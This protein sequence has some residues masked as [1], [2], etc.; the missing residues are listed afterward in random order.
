LVDR[1]L[2]DGAAD[3]LA[4]DNL[5]TGDWGH[6][7]R[8]ANDSRLVRWEADFAAATPDVL[9]A[10]LQ[11]CDVLFHLAAEKHNQ[12]RDRPTRVFDVNVQGTWRLLEAAAAAG[13]RKVV[14]T[15]SLYA[16]GGMVGPALDEADRPNPWTAYGISKLAGEQMLTHFRRVH[17]LQSAC[18]R[19]FFTYG[20]RQ[21]AGMGYKSVI[22][23]S[24]E[25]L[26]AGEP[27]AICGSGQQ[28]LDYVYIDDVVDALVRAAIR[29]IGEE[30]VNIASGI[31]RSVAEL[32]AAIAA[33][34][35]SDLSPRHVAADW[36]EGTCR[37]GT[38]ER[39]ARLL[40]WR[41]VTPLEAGLEATYAWMRQA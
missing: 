25:H 14:F 23:R 8:W 34:A 41:A 2:V 5:H 40:D 26:M 21:F 9:R 15:S 28:I 3:V 18:V 16:H 33:T 32:V 27:A 11:G 19:L 38:I 17:G 20:P 24:F 36:T 12:S 22:L 1:L 7:D 30:P 39:A 31:G 35:G 29:E 4:C 37:V 13:I 6:L 10:R